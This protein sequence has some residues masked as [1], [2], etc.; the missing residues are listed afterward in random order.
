MANLEFH[1]PVVYMES[2]DFKNGLPIIK[3]NNDYPTFLFISMDGCRYC[4]DSVKP[5]QTVAT[6]NI[7]SLNCAVLKYSDGDT[8]GVRGVIGDMKGIN[9]FPHFKYYDS[10]C[11][12]KNINVVDRSVEG[13][14][15]AI[16]TAAALI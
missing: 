6:N 1:Y 10:K 8:T 14:Q 2:E 12:E 7:G 11:I 16:R 5:F 9:G 15:S 13:M 3:L 4:K